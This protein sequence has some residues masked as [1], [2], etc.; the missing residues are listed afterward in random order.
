MRNIDLLQKVKRRQHTKGYPAHKR[1]YGVSIEDRPESVNRCEEFGYWE[2]DTVVGKKESSA[3]LLTLDERMTKF[4]HIIKIPMVSVLKV[5]CAPLPATT[6][7]NSPVSRSCVPIYRV[8][9]LIR[10]LPMSA[11]WMRR[12]IL[13]FVVSFPKV[14]HWMDNGSPD[15]IERTQGWINHFPRKVFRYACPAELFPYCPIW[16]CNLPWYFF[17]RKV[18]K[19]IDR[20]MRKWYYNIHATFAEVNIKR[21]FKK[22]KKD[23]DRGTADVVI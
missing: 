20:D 12:K 9:T 1:P 19:C 17:F 15:T 22:V 7:K 4:Y 10:I 2:I 3:V 5:Y 11:G 14:T 13:L 8:T 16:Y 6:A 18:I 23:V 21:S